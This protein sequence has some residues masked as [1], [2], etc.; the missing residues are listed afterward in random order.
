MRT[1]IVVGLIAAIGGGGYFLL[2][3]QSDPASEK[4]FSEIKQRVSDII[5]QAKV[6][7]NLK[8]K[9]GDVSAPGSSKK[10]KR[11][12][13]PKATLPEAPIEKPCDAL[14]EERQARN[15]LLR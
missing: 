12:A 5:E 13:T 10:S 9:A 6:R 2:R 8:G 14:L 15:R 4:R 11:S 1:L 7:F 3:A